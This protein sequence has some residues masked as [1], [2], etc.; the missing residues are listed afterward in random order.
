[1]KSKIFIRHL[2]CAGIL[3][4]AFIG[5]AAWSQTKPESETNLILEEMAAL[6]RAFKTVIDALVLGDMQR[7]PPALKEVAEAREKVEQAIKTGQ[8]I[9]LPKNQSQLREFLR[10]DE[11]F[12][13][14]LEELNKSAQT[15]Q[16]KAV[17]NY[18]HK[19]LDACVV[20]HEKYRK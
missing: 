12:H 19:I 9:L 17:R 6:D 2:F 4:T 7:I 11:Q 1:M 8:K 5:T 15:D 16:K 18:A 10:L 14:D 20:C 3:G 13:V